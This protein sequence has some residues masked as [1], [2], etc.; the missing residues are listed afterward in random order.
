MIVTNS[1]AYQKKRSDSAEIKPVVKG[2]MEEI[3][4]ARAVTGEELLRGIKA[5][6]REMYGKQ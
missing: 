2:S 5:D 6:I 3:D 1:T 4:L